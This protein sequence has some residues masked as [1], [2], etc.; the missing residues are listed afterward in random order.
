MRADQKSRFNNQYI[1]AS[2]A[3]RR[4]GVKKSTLYAYVSRGKIR[5]VAGADGRSRHYL[6]SDVA[7][8]RQQSDARAGH[9][10]VAAGALRWGEPVLETAIADV[11]S[12]EGPRYRGIA[13]T[14]LVHRNVCFER[15]A[16][17]LWGA[18]VERALAGPAPRWPA[19]RAEWAA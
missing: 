8:V 10:A 16:E 18:D 13:A 4:L 9:T 7:R 6:A 12:D 5:R 19:P 2:E 3:A 15:A 11:S 17:L 1:D 14:E